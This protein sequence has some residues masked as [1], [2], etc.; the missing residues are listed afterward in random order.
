[1]SAVVLDRDRAHCR[2]RRRMSARS[3]LRMLVVD[4]GQI[5]GSDRIH[6][7]QIA[8]CFVECPERIEVRQIADVLAA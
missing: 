5:A 3:V 6:R 2:N 7:E 8:N 4:D 1:V